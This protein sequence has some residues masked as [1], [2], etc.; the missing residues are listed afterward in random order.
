MIIMISLSIDYENSYS[1]SLRM[2][3][4]KIIIKAK[5]KCSHPDPSEKKFRSLLYK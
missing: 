3:E 5:K 2:K 4:K 1:V